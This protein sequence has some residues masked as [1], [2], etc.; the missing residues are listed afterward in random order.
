MVCRSTGQTPCSFEHACRPRPILLQCY[1]LII[2]VMCNISE[3]T[4]SGCYHH[5]H[6][7]YGFWTAG[8]CLVPNPFQSTFAW[9]VPA[10]NTSMSYTS[11]MAGEPRNLDSG[12]CNPNTG[13]VNLW[14]AWFHAWNDQPCHWRFCSVCEID[15]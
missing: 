12:D 9:K 10:N 4:L 15:M 5:K 3:N 13:C 6:L 8:H 11:W 7:G 14:S 1:C 2:F